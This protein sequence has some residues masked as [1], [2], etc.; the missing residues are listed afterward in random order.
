MK[1]NAILTYHSLD[2]SG[3]VISVRPEVFRRQMEALAASSVKAVPLNELH[4]HTGAVAITF[5]DGF[6]NLAEHAVPVLTRL[7]LPATIFVVSGYCGM[8]NNWPTQPAGIPEMPLLSWTALRDLPPSIALGAH[9]VTHPNLTALEQPEMRK[10]VLDS[11]TEIEQRTGRRVDTF[12]YPYGTVNAITAALVGEQF[13]VACGTR[14]N[15]CAP[16]S[17]RAQLPR[18]DTFYLQSESWFEDPFG[19]K[20]RLYVDFR[21]RLRELRSGR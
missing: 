11:R 13:E 15:F 18:L 16:E 12:A 3:S 17:D 20:T 5:D 8:R 2:P 9:T 6:G 10:E 19:W 7:A 21:R 1:S 4:R 14:L